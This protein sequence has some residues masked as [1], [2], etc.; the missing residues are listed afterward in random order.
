M[1]YIKIGNGDTVSVSNDAGPNDWKIADNRAKRNSLLADSDSMVLQDRLPEAK[2]NEWKE[3]RK[4]LR[5][6]DFSDLEKIVFPA[7]PE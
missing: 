4:K 2:V 3:Y 1:H 7:K 6:M 5:D